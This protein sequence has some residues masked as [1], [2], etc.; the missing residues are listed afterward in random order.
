M[1]IRIK[2]FFAAP[3]LGDEEKQ[4]AAN[5]LNVM[6][7]AILAFALTMAVALTFVNTAS[8]WG[9]TA[10]VV[11]MGSLVFSMLVMRALIR[12][13]LI[14]FTSILISL[15]LWVVTTFSIY[16]FYGI[17]NSITSGFFLCI[18]IAGLLLGGRA[19]II[20]S[21]F[22][23]AAML[24][25]WYAETSGGVVYDLPKL[26]PAFDALA[27]SGIFIVGGLLL[28]Y[29]VRNIT[30]SL[31]LARRNEHAQ[32]EANRELQKLQASLEKQVADRTRDLERRTTYLEASAQVS[33]AASSILDVD[34]L[35]QQVVE[36]IRERFGMY[37]V[38]LFLADEA[39]EWAELEAGTGEGGRTMLARGHRVPVGGGTAVGQSIALGQSRVARENDQDTVRLAAA[40]LPGTRS[41]AALPLHSRGLVNGALTVH[42]D[43]PDVFDNAAIGVLQSMA[44]QVAVALDNARLFAESQAAL[45]AERRAYGQYSREM[46][47][48]MMRAGLTSG[49]AFTRKQVIPIGNEWSPEMDA[50]LREDKSVVVTDPAGTTL[51]LPIRVRGQTIGVVDVRKS[52]EGGD[53]TAEEVALM[54][55]LSEQLGVALESARLFQD[56]QRHGASEQLTAQITSRMRETLDVETVLRTTTEELYQ[57]FNLAEAEVR[58]GPVSDQLTTGQAGISGLA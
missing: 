1:L 47:S 24:G 19:T 14:R 45:E 16:K 33:Q 5:L 42:S 17:R 53:W 50:I 49:Y 18:V 37:Y 31:E 7:N 55:S 54:E 4:R 11:I 40:D 25:V 6:V 15:A 26:P 34:Q 48:Q 41:E 29:A 20:F 22:S 28:R 12:L 13:G 57:V 23:V 21:L 43:R 27:Y 52:A 36:L 51:A 44:D 10:N 58:L 35:T 56:T 8:F 2:Q 3:I 32:I 46:W 38:G 30:R 39:G 9:N